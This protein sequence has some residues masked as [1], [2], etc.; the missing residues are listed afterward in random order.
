MDNLTH[1]LFAVTL[2]RTPLGRAGRGTTTALVLA[3]NAPDIDILATARGTAAYLR[4]HRGPTHGPLGFVA[5]SLVTAAIVW[6]IQRYID[7]NA[8]PPPNTNPIDALPSAS[9]GM[10][11]VASAVGLLCHIL[12]DF[13]TSYGTRVFSPFGW[14]W[15]GADLMPIVDIYLIAALIA[16]LLFG[17]TSEASRRRN[18]AIVLA[19]MAANYGV[20]AVAHHEAIVLAPRVFGPLMPKP[21]DPNRVDRPLIVEWPRSDSAM[22]VA[23]TSAG[24]SRCLVDLAAMPTFLSPFKWRLIA[25]LSNAYEMHDLDVLDARLRRPAEVGEAPWRVTVRYPD[26]WNPMVQAAAHAPLAQV[27]LGFSRY[28]AARWNVD[29]RTGVAT[30]RWTDMRFANGLTVDQRLGRANLFTATVHVAPD[31]RVLD[32][33]LGQ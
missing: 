16:G 31:G 19:L 25:H 27:F 17:Q 26:Q 15:F 14:H 5:L 29:Q 3:S 13:P 1:T 30:V 21:C 4:W 9:F 6:A 2:G 28:P 20:R 18:A 24:G 11:L 8:D 23:S 10:L 32:E 7:R 22:P 12:M 33:Q